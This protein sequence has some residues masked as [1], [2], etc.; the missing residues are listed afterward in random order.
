MIVMV[1]IAFVVVHP[2][3]S[4]GGEGGGGDGRDCDTMRQK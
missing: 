3:E 4:G 1:P 2:R